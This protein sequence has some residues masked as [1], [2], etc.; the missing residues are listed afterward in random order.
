MTV[1]L[2]LL[3]PHSYLDPYGLPDHVVVLFI[4]FL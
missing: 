2:P 1:C 3:P 4:I